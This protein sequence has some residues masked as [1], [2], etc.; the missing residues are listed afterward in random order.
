MLANV[1]KVFKPKDHTLKIWFNMQDRKSETEEENKDADYYGKKDFDD[2]SV[3][4]KQPPF[5][6]KMD[7]QRQQSGLVKQ[8]QN[9]RY[10]YLSVEFSKKSQFSWDLVIYPQFIIC[11]EANEM[12]FFKNCHF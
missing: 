10:L 4:H 11:N 1:Q 3:N 9:L 8:T 2:I 7:E 6:I 12:L 5:Y